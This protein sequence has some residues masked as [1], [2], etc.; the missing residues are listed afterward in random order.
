ME[1]AIT[2]YRDENIS[3]KIAEQ[4]RLRGIDAICVHDLGLLGDEDANHLKRASEMDRILVTTDVDFLR[5]AAEGILH[6]GIIFGIQQDHTLGDWV[7]NLEL[8]CFILAP[9]DMDNHVEY[10]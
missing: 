10:L 6:K 8:I 9:E 3:P 1:V 2:L 7:K 5:L 4:L